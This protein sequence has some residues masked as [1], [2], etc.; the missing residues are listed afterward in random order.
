MVSKAWKRFM[1]EDPEDPEGE[2]TGYGLVAD[3]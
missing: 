3:D 1:C 2:G